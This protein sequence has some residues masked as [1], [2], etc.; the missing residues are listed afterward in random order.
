[1]LDD[2]K[3]LFH[4][5]DGLFIQCQ[6][7]AFFLALGHFF[8]KKQDAGISRRVQVA[9]E[10]LFYFVFCLKENKLHL[11]DASCLHVHTKTA[12]KANR[13]LKGSSSSRHR[14]SVRDLSFL[15]GER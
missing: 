15:G 4:D 8:Q 11:N 3:L 9:R 10:M 6:F 13:L 2:D 14:I 7:K 5:N 12:P 1:M